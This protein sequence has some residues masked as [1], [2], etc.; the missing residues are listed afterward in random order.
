MADGKEVFTY[1]GE[2]H[3]CVKRILSD[4]LG[5]GYD[6][7]LSIE[8]HMTTV[9]HDKSVVSTPEARMDNFRTYAHRFEDM[10]HG[11]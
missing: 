5:S 6:G 1:P 8:P 2:G 9:F 3:G 11:I 7:W 4:L 10:L